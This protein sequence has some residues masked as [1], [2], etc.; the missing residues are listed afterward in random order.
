MWYKDAKQSNLFFENKSSK[1]DRCH[2]RYR[3][4]K[5]PIF[6]IQREIILRQEEIQISSFDGNLELNN[7]AI[8]L[9]DICTIH[10]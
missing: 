9:T 5:F 10:L 7:V 4:F 2:F 6:F 3:L 1:N 8:L